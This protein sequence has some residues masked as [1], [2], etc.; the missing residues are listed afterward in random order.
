[1]TFFQERIA[2]WSVCAV[3]AM[4]VAACGGLSTRPN[5]GPC[6]IAGALYEAERVIVF[7]GPSD[8]DNVA[9][10]GAIVDVD[11]T[12][13]Y[14]GDNPISIDLEIAFEFGRG[15]AADGRRYAYPYFVTV[16]RQGQALLTKEVFAEPVTFPNDGSGVRRRVEHDDITIPRAGE[17]T[18]G[19]NFEIIVGFQLTPEQLAFNRSRRSLVA[20]DL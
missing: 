8:L 18:S 3:L 19:S 9:F 13:R 11:A 7:D 20:P 4:A 10:S 15:P 17:A 6:P 1:M 14:F 2:G 5:A 16:T 12:C